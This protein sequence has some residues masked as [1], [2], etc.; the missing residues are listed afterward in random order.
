LVAAANFASGTCP[1][2]D[3]QRKDG[4]TNY[5]ETLE[6]D[7]NYIKAALL[8]YQVTKKPGY[9][10]KAQR[11]YAAVRKYFLG[12]RVPLYTAYVFDRGS[13]CIPQQGQHFA[14][15]NGDMIWAGA[16][17]AQLTGR[18]AYLAQ[19][20]GSGQAVRLGSAAIRPVLAAQL[21]VSGSRGPDQD[22]HLRPVFR[23]PSAPMLARSVLFAWRWPERGD[24]SITVLPELRQKEGS[25]LFHMIGYYLVC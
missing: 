4:G 7:S 17:L 11:K 2:I 21:R 10:A 13:E 6:T 25:T 16:T 23:R 18:K 15:V 8:L 24:H 9:L 3:Y 12:A 5:L 14:S 22:G 20:I 1:S 19:A